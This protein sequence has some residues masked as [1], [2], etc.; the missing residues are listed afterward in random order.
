L[1]KQAMA[2]RAEQLLAGKG[3][4]PPMLR[5]AVGEAQPAV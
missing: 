2:L 5:P 3:W 4:L 1:K